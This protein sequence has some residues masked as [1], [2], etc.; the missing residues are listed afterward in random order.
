MRRIVLDEFLPFSHK[1]PGTLSDGQY[2]F[3]ER[4]WE[5]RTL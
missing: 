1:R 4:R 3:L 2:Q 5:E